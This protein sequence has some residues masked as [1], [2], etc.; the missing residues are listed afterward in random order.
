MSEAIKAALMKLDPKDNTQWT[1]DG[2]PKL[3]ALKLEGVKRAEVVKAAPHFTRDHPSLDTPATQKAL[4]DAAEA[5]GVV[6]PDKITVAMAERDDAREVV[7][8]AEAVMREAQQDLR[9]ALAA[10]DTKERE[11]AALVGQRST[12]HDIMDYLAASNA[13]RLEEA[14]SNGKLK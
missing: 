2:A 7:A 5:A 11:L 1:A 3:E 13:R 14:R 4:E 12:Q 10:L 8:G 6:N 9:K